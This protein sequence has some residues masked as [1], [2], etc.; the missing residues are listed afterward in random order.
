MAFNEDKGTKELF[1]GSVFKN[2]FKERKNLLKDSDFP[3]AAKGVQFPDP[4]LTLG[5]A[6]YSFKNNA[7][8]D[9]IAYK[10][11][12]Q[13][14]SVRF[15]DE[16]K[17]AGKDAGW[18][19]AAKTKVND[20]FT[21]WTKYEHQNGQRGDVKSGMTKNGTC[22][23]LGGEWKAL[24][25]A[26]CGSGKMNMNNQLCKFSTLFNANQY[27]AG[28]NAGFECKGLGTSAMNGEWNKMLFNVGASYKGPF[29]TTMCSVG[30]AKNVTVCHA[31][32][33]DK[34]L[35]VAAEVVHPLGNAKPGHTMMA[36]V[37]YKFDSE[38]TLKARIN[39]DAQCQVAVKKTLQPGLHVLA[40]TTVD[41]QSKDSLGDLLMPKL[42]FK[43]ASDSVLFC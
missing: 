4:C 6:T 7:K 2:I 23:V 35:S 41:L 10:G 26:L 20:N 25:G 22:Y 33:V 38:T 43:I 13:E 29:G 34:T 31:Y 9:K 40:C 8:A 19:V 5:N 30:N 12:D 24:N 3:A 32:Q 11:E 28:L 36:G 27:V 15:K 18:E 14:Y 39:N 1:K 37:N 17:K 16:D 42:G 21:L